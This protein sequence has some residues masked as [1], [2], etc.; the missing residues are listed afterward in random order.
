MNIQL[1][2][3]RLAATEW[4]DQKFT[5]LD[6]RNAL[7]RDSRWVRCTFTNVRLSQADFGNATFVECRFEGCD[8]RQAVLISRIYHTEFVKC[9]FDQA[10]F[11]GADIQ[12]ARFL[13]SRAEYSKWDSSTVIRSRIDCSLRGANLDFGLTDG[14]DFTGS[15]L[16]SAL[17]P[18]NC[19]GLVGNTFDKRQV[20]L[21]LATLCKGVIPEEDRQAVSSIVSPRYAKMVDRLVSTYH[22][23]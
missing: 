10:L 6:L 15:N 2:R 12:D 9:D 8:L 22:G 23:Q 11:S 1:G 14:V 3:R 4:V 13:Q 20:H 5:N 19:Q 16:W 7:A 18:M 21:F 17:V